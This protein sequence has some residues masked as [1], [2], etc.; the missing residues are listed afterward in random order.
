MWGY[1]AK[2]RTGP[3]PSGEKLDSLI[4]T[5]KVAINK[6]R[7][8]GGDVLLV[9]TPSSGPFWMGEQQGFPREKYWDKLLASTNSQGIHFIDYPETANFICPEFSHLSPQDAI[10]YTKA[11]IPM[12]EQKGWKF[13]HKPAV[14]KQLASK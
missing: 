11:L 9:R 12:V 8:R 14:Q 4:N 7:S 5:V 13:P 10:V 3:P 1:L 6:I 2:M